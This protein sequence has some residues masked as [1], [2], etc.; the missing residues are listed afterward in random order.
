M[1]PFFH[2]LP[3]VRTIRFARYILTPRI[4]EIRNKIFETPT[5]PEPTR[6]PTTTNTPPPTC[7]TPNCELG[8]TWSGSDKSRIIF[9]VHLSQSENCAN[10]LLAVPLTTMPYAQLMLTTFYNHETMHKTVVRTCLAHRSRGCKG[11]F[12]TDSY[13]TYIHIHTS[14]KV[15]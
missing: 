12:C 1:V 6:P 3:S 5:H 15:C 7:C 8:Q 13:S 11:D 10:I 9:I 14:Q 4:I 2:E